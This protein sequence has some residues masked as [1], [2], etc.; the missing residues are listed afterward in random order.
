MLRPMSV[1]RAYVAA[2][3]AAMCACPQPVDDIATKTRTVASGP[4]LR[5]LGTVQ[6]GGLPHPA[7]TC[8]HCEAARA[9][10]DRRRNVV[11]LGLVDPRADMVVLVDATPDIR[12]QL[13]ALRDARNPPWGR[14]DRHPVDALLLTHAHMGHYVGLSFLGFEA[15]HA[16]GIDVHATDAMLGFLQSNQPWK[17]M[18]ELGELRPHALRPGATATFGAISVTPLKVPHRDELSD[19]VGYRIAGPRSK[20]LYIPD[21][22]PWS[23]WP[24]PVE[25]QLRDVDIAILDGT[26]YDRDEL[27]GREV[28]EIGHPLIVD[29]MARFAPLIESGRIEIWFSHMNHS[30]PVLDP[31]SAAAR[32]VRSRGFGILAEHVTLQL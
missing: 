18:L 30:N 19:T 28:T 22:E 29:S 5:V 17:Q 24:S 6:D 1:A 3:A 23:R 10:P 20:V 31:Q 9:R 8:E 12:D 11:S 26:F 25:D 4:Q 16:V 14:V 15:V 2:L 13:A 27:P 7:C 32:D 21:T